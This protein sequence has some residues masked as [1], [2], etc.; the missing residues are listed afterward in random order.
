MH[1]DLNFGTGKQGGY[2]IAA[3]ALLLF[4][5]ALGG[6][7]RDHG[8]RLALVELASLPALALALTSVTR[9]N[10]LPL[11]RFPLT[12]LLCLLALPLVQL[13]PLPPMIWNGLPGRD[14]MSLALDLGG[15]TQGWS[16]LS[17]TPDKTWRSFLAL[18]P[19]VAMFTCV[20]ACPPD[21]RRRLINLLLLCALLGMGL[22]SLQMISGGDQFYPW[23]TTD[24]G[25]FVGFFANRNHMATLCL[26]SLPFAV[27]LGTR[28]MRTGLQ[29]DKLTFWLSA[30]YVVFAVVALGIIRSRTGII[31]AAPVLG[32]SL[33]AAWVASGRG[34]PKWP[35]LLTVIGASAGFIAIAV[36]ALEPIL[37]RFDASGAR[38]GR[39]ENWPTIAD[40]ANTYLPL[41]SGLGSFDSVY[42]SVEPLER[43]K[44]TF[45][46]QAHNDYL[47]T[48][49]ETGWLGAALVVAFLIW[50]G[51]RSWSAWR[52]SAS[53][54]RDIQRASTIAIGVILLHS[55]VDYPL[56][57][58]TI[59]T[60]FGLLCALLEVAGS[61]EVDRRV[62][63]LQ[64]TN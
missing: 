46:N 58:A 19:P 21:A 8:L 34:R 25:N 30:M 61:N 42:R 2:A 7:S 43:L 56:R 63:G 36:F 9:R 12:I 48:W 39:F 6:A 62:I 54:D 57:T 64:S 45:F 29:S 50:F 27:V 33:I 5:F 35:L 14:Q 60:I 41:G 23:R 17:L 22:G 31:L 52:A 20:L 49:L 26:I 1:A 40:A 47:E 4:A 13:I 55:A 24:A 15:V 16:P 51:R 53:T 59:A 11:A 10:V 18:L 37:Q 28:V 3:A 44:A 38:E 32:A